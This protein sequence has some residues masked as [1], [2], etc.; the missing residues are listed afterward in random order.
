[1]AKP[2]VEIRFGKHGIAV[3]FF[4]NLDTLGMPWSPTHFKSGDWL[5]TEFSGG[6]RFVI[7]EVFENE[8]KSHFGENI[9]SP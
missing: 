2:P 1:M 5:I 6:Q 4:S 8:E 3:R 7:N 9:C